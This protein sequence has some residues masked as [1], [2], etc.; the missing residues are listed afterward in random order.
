MFL[1]VFVVISFGIKT[2]IINATIKH[3]QQRCV[4]IFQAYLYDLTTIFEKTEEI[5]ICISQ[6]N[7]FYIYYVCY[8]VETYFYTKTYQKR[9]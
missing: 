3:V 8:D 7:R 2:K 1:N 6:N 5:D 9:P 4:N